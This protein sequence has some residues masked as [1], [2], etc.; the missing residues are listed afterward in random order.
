MKDRPSDPEIDFCPIKKGGVLP[1]DGPS[2]FYKKTLV[3]T[4]N[5]VRVRK[6]LKKAENGK[7][8]LEQPALHLKRDTYP[9][10]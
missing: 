1:K 10:G 7:S 9:S 2:I 4:K 8:E 3:T 5:K 6:V